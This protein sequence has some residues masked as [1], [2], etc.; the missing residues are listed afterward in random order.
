MVPTTP[1]QRLLF[2]AVVFMLAIAPFD[3]GAGR[4]L[5]PLTA[6]AVTS[7]VLLAAVA[8][9]VVLRAT[10][11]GLIRFP[12][13]VA[14]LVFVGVSAASAAWSIDAFVSLLGLVRVLACATALL[15]VVYELPGEEHGRSLCVALVVWAALLAPLGIFQALLGRGQFQTEVA[16]RAHSVF[17]TPNTFAAFLIIVLPITVS[18]AVTTAGRAG[19]R[20]LWGAAAL[21]LAALV[22]S[23][24]RGGWV[25]GAAMLGLLAWLLARRRLIRF[26]LP[27]SP[28]ARRW[29]VGISAAAVLAGVGLL[30]IRP[31]IRHRVATTLRPDKAASLRERAVYWGSTADMARHSWPLGIG[32]DTYHIDYLAHRHP[33]Q[34]GTLQWFAHHDYL[35]ILVELGPL[36]LGALL[37]LIWQVARMAGVV[38]QRTSDRRRA[39][40][41]A[42][43][44]CGAAAGLLHSLV[45]YNLY[46]PATA[47]A[48]F[49]CFGIIIA[50]YR[51][52]EA[53]R[54][55]SYEP[56][57]V[58]RRLR[59]V[60]SIG[61]LVVA[62]A[63]IFLAVRPLA[64]QRILE[65]DSFDAPLA[66]TVCPWSGSYWAVLGHVHAFGDMQ[67]AFSPLWAKHQVEQLGRPQAFRDR[68]A[69]LRA[70]QT[71]IRRSPRTAVFHA[72][73]GRLLAE[74]HRS[75]RGPAGRNPGLQY[76]RRACALDRYSAQMRWYVAQ[77]CF[78]ADELREAE[79]HLM[80]CLARCRPTKGLRRAVKRLYAEIHRRKKE[81]PDHL[82]T[83][84][85][86]VVH[87]DHARPRGT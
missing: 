39:A 65:K 52:V 19:R 2:I 47:L 27:S 5:L 87:A 51:R 23:Q 72:Y 85:G 73:L 79:R 17:V 71:A 83:R 28:A 29:A 14:L 33:S 25:V 74:N 64:A 7:I 84:P 38:L 53:E 10:P 15:L 6:I 40:L 59:R 9:G 30:M 62:A 45:D 86:Q 67:A 4:D 41:V 77:A 76:L 46:V 42:G 49:V 3:E 78:E 35:Q 31:D 82:P 58:G 50:A 13:L 26:R 66:V 20:A 56:L 63:G 57:P 18:L 36:G 1:R 60:V 69:A 48:I 12:G 11:S 34:A 68:W 61:A 24:S 16:A 21:F 22:L 43:C 54:Y 37:F 81:T 70:Y 75:A 55:P 32:L 80:F 44:Y 8:R